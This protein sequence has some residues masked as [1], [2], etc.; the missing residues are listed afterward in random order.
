MSVDSFSAH[1]TE[2]TMS[3]AAGHTAVLVIDMLNDFCKPGGAMVLPGYE[4]LLPPQRTVLDAARGTGAVVVHVT[5]A[6][7]PDVRQDREFTKRTPHCIEGTWGAQIIDELTPE[8]NDLVVTKRR[9]SGF[10]NTDLDLTLKDMQVETVIAM[11]VVTN[12]CV[13]S[14]V[15][16]AF[17]HGYQVVVPE[18]CVAATGPREQASSL[19]DIGTHFGI[20]S[21]AGAV[22]AALDNGQPL[23]NRIAA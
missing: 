18:D 2:E 7:R 6:H 11:G 15:H 22:P 12:I 13:R 16:D 5:D 20:V 19:Y 3:L 4:A 23:I 8:A 10:F 1:R 9:F 14:T 21:T 17:F